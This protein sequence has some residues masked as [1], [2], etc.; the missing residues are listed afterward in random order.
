[1]SGLCDPKTHQ[2]CLRVSRRL[3]PRAF[4]C[5]ESLAKPARPW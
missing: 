3:C 2:D 1:L 4:T 5:A